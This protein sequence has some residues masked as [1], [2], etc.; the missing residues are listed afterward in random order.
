[1]TEL[2]F[3]PS[4][5]ILGNLIKTGFLNI[6][7]RQCAIIAILLFPLYVIYCTCLNPGSTAI[8]TPNGEVESLQHLLASEYIV[9]QNNMFSGSVYVLCLCIIALRR[10]HCATLYF[11]SPFYKGI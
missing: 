8:N 1:M 5:F 3:C 10:E 7:Y 2:L 11:F 9:I 4:I 6:V